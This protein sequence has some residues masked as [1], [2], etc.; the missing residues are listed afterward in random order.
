MSDNGPWREIGALVDAVRGLDQRSA[1]QVRRLEQVFAAVR[2]VHD[3]DRTL[4]RDLQA[5]RTSPEYAAAF[6]DPDPLVSVLIPT[7]RNAEGLR[8]VSLP[9]VLAQTH[10]NIEVVVVGDAAPPEVA[11]AVAS[12]DDPRIRFANLPTRGPYPEDRRRAW[13]CAGTPPY[14]AAVQLAQGT[15]IAPLGDDDEF[16]PEHVELLLAKARQDR[17][18]FVYGKFSMTTASN[19]TEVFGEFPPKEGVTGLQMSIYPAALRIFEL[20]LGDAVFDV[21]NDLGLIGRMLRTGVR[22][23]MIDE[24]VTH[25]YPST[26]AQALH[27]APREDTVETAPELG[28]ALA[29]RIG[30]LEAHEADL[31]LRVAELEREK[32]DLARRLRDVTDSKS[33]RATKP[34]RDAASRRRGGR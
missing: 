32:A 10:R 7:W 8:T 29:E 11:E 14:N 31:E 5:A 25:Y 22:F 16:S 21:S 27:P 33:W 24:I 12:F 19:G 4:R 15:W 6:E 28:A 17:L 30:A 18:E 2:Q 9:S 23:G 3:D 1:Q 20:E 34:L 26:S 13:L